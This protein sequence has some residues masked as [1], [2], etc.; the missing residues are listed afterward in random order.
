MN[1]RLEAVMK[2]HMIIIWCNNHG[3]YFE[4]EGDA[5]IIEPRKSTI[6]NV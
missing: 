6:W 2:Q 5:T 3:Y 4:M 1:E